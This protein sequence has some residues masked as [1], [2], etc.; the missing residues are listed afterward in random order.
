M[1][2]VDFSLCLVTDRRQTN[3]RPLVALI[4]EAL[5]AGLTAVQLREKDL[6]T[7]V[8]M[9]LAVEIRD[10][11]RSFGAT[12]LLNDRIDLAQVI[13]SSGVHL[14]A[15]GLPASV[16]RRILGSNQL[17]GVSTHSVEEVL[18]A[19]SDGADFVVLG[20]VYETPSKRAYGAPLG[21]SSVEEAARRAR[22]PV[23]AIGGITASRA[24]DV[25]RAGASGVAVVSAI[26]GAD[27]VTRAT[28][29]ILE[30]V[31]DAV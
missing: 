13:G 10:L 20:P 24:R 22:V 5:R 25:R 2:S 27:D 28:R 30:A 31:A 26:L 14:P 16:A 6:G 9:T 19:E 29:A 1:P 7:R 23:F 12:L 18:R 15:A 11:A 4:E 17:V 3:G 8:L 21:L